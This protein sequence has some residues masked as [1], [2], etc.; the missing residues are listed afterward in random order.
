[1]N[2][3]FCEDDIQMANESA[4]RSPPPSC[5]GLFSKR[6]VGEGVGKRHPLIPVG[7]WGA[8]WSLRRNLSPELPCDPATPPVRKSSET[9]AGIPKGRLPPRVHSSL[10]V[11]AS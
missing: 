1:M 3:S 4:G 10:D 2:R 9:D 11:E 6:R 7:T 5:Q 8:V